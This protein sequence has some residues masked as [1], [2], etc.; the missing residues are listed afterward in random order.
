[1]MKLLTILLW[2]AGAVALGIFLATSEIDGRTPLEHLQRAWKHNVNPSKI[3]RLKDGLRDAL[4][5]AKDHISDTKKPERYSD[6]E[7]RAI[8]RII[9][10][11][12]TK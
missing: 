8:D 4:D 12:P 11:S 5:D 2:T 3:D 9:A 1:M 6:D 7:R 10:K